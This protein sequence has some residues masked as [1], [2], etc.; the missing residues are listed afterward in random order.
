MY[1]EF[2]TFEFL[3]EVMQLDESFY[4]LAL[5]RQLYFDR[6]TKSR[7]SMISQKRCRDIRLPVN[8]GLQIIGQLV[9]SAAWVR[10]APPTS[11]GAF[12]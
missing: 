2:V 10:S 4:P 6:L 11:E 1:C 7:I 3:P 5:K 9:R 8:P 12:L